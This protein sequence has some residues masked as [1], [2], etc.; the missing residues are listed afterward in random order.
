MPVQ[1]GAQAHN[2]SDPTG[3]L[4]DCHRRIEM[5]LRTL[6]GVASVI[7]RPLTEETRA[8]LESALR[9]F[10]EAAPKHTADEEESLFPR[11]R[12]KRDPNMDFGART[13]GLNSRT[14]T[15]KWTR[16]LTTAELPNC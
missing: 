16:P 15:R 13:T 10:R 11:M 1:I 9:Y 8:A 12:Q 4:S 14:Q 7:D 5:F 6:E 3:L 2:F